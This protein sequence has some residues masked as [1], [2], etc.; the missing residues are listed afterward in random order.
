MPRPSDSLGGLLR[1]LA[2]APCAR[3]DGALLLAEAADRAAAALRLAAAGAL[4]GSRLADSLTPPE[5]DPAALRGEAVRLRQVAR[6]AER[7]A[8]E[9][10]DRPGHL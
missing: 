5:A 1:A 4:A 6:R 9:L 10:A 2:E 3:A 7:L 8:H